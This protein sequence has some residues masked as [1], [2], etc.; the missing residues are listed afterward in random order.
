MPISCNSWRKIGFCGVYMIILF[1]R[2]II[3][4]VLTALAV[5][6]ALSGRL[7]A[8]STTAQS[9]DPV[10]CSS[11]NL[12]TRDA[13]SAHI[14]ESSGFPATI[15]RHSPARPNSRDRALA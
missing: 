12:I 8:A 4:L 7:F 15:T 10:A 1:P 5:V 2:Q 14:P 13:S 11:L 6:V 9:R 3:P